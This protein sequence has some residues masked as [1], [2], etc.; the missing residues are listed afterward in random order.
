M[1]F[2]DILNQW[3]KD[4]AKAYGKKRIQ[5]DSHALK[6][7]DT[8]NATVQKKIDD[9][10]KAHPIDVW[11]RRNGVE[12]KDSAL[13]EEEESPAQRR[14][15]LRAMKPEAVIDLHGLT[16]EEAWNRLSL[17]FTDCNRRNVQ[18]VLIIHGKGT[19]SEQGSVLRQMVTLFLEQNLHAGESGIAQKDSGGSGATW[20]LLK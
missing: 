6:N 11:M 5:Q 1:N 14:R 17:F 8:Q 2:E 9:E 15:Q 20:V 7:A 13:L 16:R 10:K 4:T 3:E 18:K 12:D 19:H